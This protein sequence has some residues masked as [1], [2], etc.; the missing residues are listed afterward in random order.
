MINSD[1]QFEPTRVIGSGATP[2]E[3]E[4]DNEETSRQRGKTRVSTSTKLPGANRVTPP[5]V[6]PLVDNG[7]SMDEASTMAWVS[8]VN[9]FQ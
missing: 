1:V 9:R 3:L 6:T 7:V 8:R 4:T 5:L 2:V